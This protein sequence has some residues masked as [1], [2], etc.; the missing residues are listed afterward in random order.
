MMWY[1]SYKL[2]TGVQKLAEASYISRCEIITY[3]LNCLEYLVCWLA[4]D[5]AISTKTR[6]RIYKN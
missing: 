6:S 1:W 3:K 4:E 2:L 5:A